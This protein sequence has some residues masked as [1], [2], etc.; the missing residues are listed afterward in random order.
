MVDDVMLALPPG[1][2]VNTFGRTGGNIPTDGEVRDAILELIE[3]GEA[4]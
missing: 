1:I 2:P 3:E 4:Q